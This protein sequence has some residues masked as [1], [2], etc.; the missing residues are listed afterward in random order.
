[1]REE[2]A[3]ARSV[4]CMLLTQKIVITSSEVISMKRK[5]NKSQMGP[6][7]II[8]TDCETLS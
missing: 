5:S 1:M 4:R 8:G 7:A 3:Q 6:A 2:G